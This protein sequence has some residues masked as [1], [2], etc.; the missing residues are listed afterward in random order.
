MIR[1]DLPIRAIS[2]SSDEKLLAIGSESMLISLISI[3]DPT[4]GRRDAPSGEHKR[5]ISCLAFDPKGEFLASIDLSGQLI[6]WEVASLKPVD[7][8]SIHVPSKYWPKV[9]WSQDGQVLAVTG[10]DSIKLI[11]RGEWTTLRHLSAHLPIDIAWSLDGSILLSY[12]ES[13][14]ALWNWR[15]GKVWRELR[16]SLKVDCMALSPNSLD[17]AFVDK[18][19]VL[20]HQR[21]LLSPSDLASIP[22]A[23]LAN[24]NPKKKKQKLKVKKD[25]KDDEE[26]EERR[27]RQLER[28]Y[29]LNEADDEDDDEGSGIDLD[30][31]SGG[32]ESE[33]EE[34]ND[35]DE[36]GLDSLNDYDL[37]DRFGE[38]DVDG[39]LPMQ[40][41]TP[42][43][44]I[45][46]SHHIPFQPGATDPQSDHRFMVWNLVGLIVSR[47]DEAG[48]R[49]I[50]IEF[51]DKL[52]TRPIRFIDDH[53]FSMGTLSKDA[54]LFSTGSQSQSAADQSTVHYM[55][56][57]TWNGRQTWTYQLG[58]GESVL[59]VALND[60]IAFVATSHGWIRS[61]T[62]TG[63][64]LPI[65]TFGGDFV[66][67]VAGNDRLLVV[68]H[69]LGCLQSRLLTIP[70]DGTPSLDFEGPIGRRA[71]LNRLLWAGISDSGLVACMDQ[72]G[73]V[74]GLTGKLGFCW[75]PIGDFSGYLAN[76]ETVWPIF[77]DR[78]ELSCVLCKVQ[79]K[80]T[81]LIHSNLCSRNTLLSCRDPS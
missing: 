13:S 64:Q 17:L 76:G 61:F 66:T 45:S 2:L 34:D 42:E 14:L 74:Y 50:D 59:G 1:T 22:L 69:H 43:T 25:T 58:E 81:Y 75:T 51:H 4:G 41:T 9:A 55:A 28:K 56:F 71:D 80:H 5:P 19:G 60:S 44:P 27:I 39:R 12:D 79:K 47:Q 57:E 24:N 3:D 32:D 20:H 8:T 70:Q 77:L 46:R 78:N 49:S 21:S 35:R 30:N 48:Y 37:D 38:E 15:D 18:E 40:E 23:N 54:A 33:D 68:T 53:G 26:A 67:M 52:N 29:M 62:A 73:I 6:V 72:T 36:E 65:I 63:L 31:T 10:E 7:K 11:Q 16:H